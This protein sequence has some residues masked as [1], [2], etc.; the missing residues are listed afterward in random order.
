MKEDY[1]RELNKIRKERGVPYILYKNLCA[2]A[3]VFTSN[4][5]DRDLAHKYAYQIIKAAIFKVEE[6]YLNISETHDYGYRRYSKEL[7]QQTMEELNIKEPERI[8]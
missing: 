8:L 1:V 5:I 7:I 2:Y 3:L 4:F 6:K